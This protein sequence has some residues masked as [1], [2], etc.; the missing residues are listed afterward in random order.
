[1]KASHIVAGVTLA[2]SLGSVNAE[3]LTVEKLNQL[4]QLHDVSISPKGD[5]LIY[6]LK[7]GTASKDNHLYRQDIK[8]GKVTQL[9]NHANSE[10]NVVW[11]DDGQSIYFLSSRSGSSQIWQL[12]LTGGEAV[13]ISDYP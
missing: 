8:S 1:M 4:N 3:V 9:T 13:Q 10:H 11:A 7:K 5:A 12:P 2:A 6:G